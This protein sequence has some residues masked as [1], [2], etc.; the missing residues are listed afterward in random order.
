MVVL[1]EDVCFYCRKTEDLQRCEDCGLVA[2]CGDSHH[3][4]LHG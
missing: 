4:D 3:W 2:V 1:V